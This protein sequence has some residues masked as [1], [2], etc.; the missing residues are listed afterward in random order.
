MSIKRR[1]I[2]RCCCSVN[3]GAALSGAVE[4]VPMTGSGSCGVISLNGSDAGIDGTVV[5]CLR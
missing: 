4:E 3:D 2:S 5:C 1:I